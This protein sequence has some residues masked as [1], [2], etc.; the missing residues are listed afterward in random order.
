MW[1]IQAGESGY[2]YENIRIVEKDGFRYVERLD[3]KPVYS[4][5]DDKVKL[6]FEPVIRKT[7][8]IAKK[9]VH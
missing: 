2:V 3:G 1:T 6:K 4:D 7:K 9:G 5:E 8:K